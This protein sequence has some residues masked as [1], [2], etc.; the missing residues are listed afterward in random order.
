MKQRRKALTI[1]FKGDGVTGGL[2]RKGRIQEELEGKRRGNLSNLWWSG[3][4]MGGREGPS[5]KKSWQGLGS[6]KIDEAIMFFQV[7]KVHRAWEKKQAT[8][9][10]REKES[11]RGKSK[12]DLTQGKTLREKTDHRGDINP[13]KGGGSSFEL[14]ECPGMKVSKIRELGESSEGQKERAD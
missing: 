12:N 14:C 1:F 6:K 8:R 9:E 5:K 3:G 4:A 13:K 10:E 11:E 7:T 2:L